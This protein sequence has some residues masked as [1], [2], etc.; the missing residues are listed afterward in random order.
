MPS[1]Y[2]F[3]DGLSLKMKAL[4]LFE[5]SVAVHQSTRNNIPEDL[6][7][8]ERRSEN[9]KCRTVFV[10]V[11]FNFMLS[12]WYSYFIQADAG[13]KSSPFCSQQFT[14]PSLIDVFFADPRKK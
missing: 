13:N 14:N 6:N 11:R 1:S 8:P 5:T 4:R 3:Y 7:L 10:A 2:V 9:L 12:F